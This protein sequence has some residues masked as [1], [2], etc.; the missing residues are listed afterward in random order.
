M[1]LSM[2]GP[3]RSRWRAT[4][5]ALAASA[6]LV[7]TAGSG[8]S[9]A[10]ATTAVQHKMLVVLLENHSRSET[11]ARMPHLKAL[12]KRYGQAT[13]YYAVRHPSLPNYLAIWGGSTFGVRNDCA[14]GS[15]N[16]VA[17]AP[18]VFGQTLAAHKTAKAYQESMAKNCQ[19]TGSKYYAPR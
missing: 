8:V 6:L 18:S 13:N 15:Y 1:H 4:A 5:A 19:T 3:I 2:S 14:V 10:R 17:T 12:A 7:I 9:P 11:L 16:C